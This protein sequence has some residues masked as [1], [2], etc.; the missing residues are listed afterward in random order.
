MVTNITIFNKFI[1]S[2]L[3][4]INVL[5]VYTYA[6]A[7][8]CSSFSNVKFFESAVNIV[9]YNNIVRC[10]WPVLGLSFTVDSNLVF[11]LYFSALKTLFHQFIECCK[12]NGR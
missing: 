11:N 8:I 4:L 5:F 1:F 3:G 2:V 10:S 6:V 9:Y 7:Y 12:V